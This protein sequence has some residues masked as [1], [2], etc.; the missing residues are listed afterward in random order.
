MYNDASVYETID[1]YDVTPIYPWVKKTG[2]MPVG[3]PKII[4][5]KIRDLDKYKGLVKCK[6]LPP[7]RLYHLIL[8]TK[9]NGKLFNMC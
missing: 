5:E 8:P 9:M 4:T 7:K 2:I 1:Y 6:V 3:H